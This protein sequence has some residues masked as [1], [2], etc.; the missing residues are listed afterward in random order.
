MFEQGLGRRPL[1]VGSRL[2]AA[3]ES[4]CFLFELR[5]AETLNLL[6]EGLYQRGIGINASEKHEESLLFLI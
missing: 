2:I 4:V 3:A 1:G 6:L 5:N